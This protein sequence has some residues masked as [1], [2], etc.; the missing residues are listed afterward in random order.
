MAFQDKTL[1]AKTVAEISFLLQGSR[2]FMRRKVLKMNLHVAVIAGMQKNAAG[3]GN[4]S[5]CKRKC[6][7]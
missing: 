7:M 6:I 3:K 1:N 5:L 4:V 2:S